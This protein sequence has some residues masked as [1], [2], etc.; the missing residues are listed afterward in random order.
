MK[1]VEVS[2]TAE[3]IA[4]GEPDSCW[5]CPIA[6]AA[7]DAI[8]NFDVTVNRFQIG[9]DEIDG[10][11]APTWVDLPDEAVTFI[12]RFDDGE[13]VEPFTFTMQVPEEVAA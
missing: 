13:P 5:G 9:I 6:L 8:P 3:H 1:T 11:I 4:G 2:V 10:K 12:D 7:M